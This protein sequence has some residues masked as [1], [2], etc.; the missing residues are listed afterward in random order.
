MAMDLQEAGVK[1]E[2]MTFTGQNLTKMASAVLEAFR[3]KQINLY[4]D[5]DLVRDLKRISIQEIVRLELTATRTKEGHADRGTALAIA[6]LGG[7]NCWQKEAQLLLPAAARR[8]MNLHPNRGRHPFT[9]AVRL[10]AFA[11][12]NASGDS[13]HMSGSN[14]TFTYAL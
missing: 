2:E 3:G 12:A 10:V 11:G 4:D 9:A 5:K 8:R 13:I 1:M 14:M 7:R 6:S